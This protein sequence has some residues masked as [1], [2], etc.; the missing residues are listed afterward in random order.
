MYQIG[1]EYDIPDNIDEGVI[2]DEATYLSY[3][4]NGQKKQIKLSRVAYWIDDRQ[5]LLIF[6][7]NHFDLSAD[8]I[9]L[10]YKKRWQIKTL[11]KQ[12]KQ[13]VPLK[14]FLGDNVNAI[15][16]QIWVSLIANLLLSQGLREIG[17]S[18]I[19]HQ[20]SDSI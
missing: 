16:I 14:Y 6:I 5:R 7:S 20:L 1:E 3:N 12:L 11:F 18:Q 9:A 17:H 10:I 2:K 15:E 4:E 19:W 8:M 13:N